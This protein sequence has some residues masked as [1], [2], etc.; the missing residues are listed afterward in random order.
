MSVEERV[1]RSDR[2]SLEVLDFVRIQGELLDLTLSDSGRQ[3]ISNEP[4]HIDADAL[5]TLQRQTAYI[6][7]LFDFNLIRPRYTFPALDSV[8]ASLRVPGRSLDAPSLLEVANYL[9]AA[10][11]LKR[12][13]SLRP[14]ERFESPIVGELG[15][16][17]DLPELGR[18]IRDV[19]SDDGEVREDIASIVAILRRLKETRANL[20]ILARRYLQDRRDFWQ[21]DVP[22]IKDDRTVLPL[23]SDHRGSVRGIVRDVSNTGATIFIEP[24]EIVD[25]NNEISLIGHEY[26]AEIARILRETTT[27]VRAHLPR[28][29]ALESAVAKLDSL[30]ARARFGELHAGRSAEISEGGVRLTSARHPLLG[31]LALP[32]D[33]A[34]GRACSVII[35]GPNAGGKTV[36]LKTIGLFAL[37]HQFGIPLPVSDGA[38][39][40]LFD[41][42]FA[43]V[44]DEQSIDESLSTFSGHARNLSRFLA[45]ATS[46][47]LVLLDELGSGTDPVEGAAIAMAVVDSLLDRGTTVVVT[48]HHGVLK[49][50]GYT[51]ENAV[52]ASVSFDSK[53]HAP[54]Y[55]VVMGTPGESHALDVAESSGIPTEVVAKARAYLDDESSDVAAMISSLTVKQLQLEERNREFEARRAALSEKQREVDLTSL[56]LKQRELE[57]RT[58]GYSQLTKQ[59]DEHRSRLERLVQEVKLGAGTNE[60]KAVKEYVDDL[61]TAVNEEREAIEQARYE[62]RPVTSEIMPGMQVVVGESHQR[63]TVVRR[64]KKGSWVVATD[65]VRITLPEHAIRGIVSDPVE[66]SVQADVPN[67]TPP[68]TLDLRGMRLVEAIEAVSVQIDRSIASGLQAFDVIHGLGEGVLKDGVREF[69]SDEPSVSEFSFAPPDQGGYGKTVVRLV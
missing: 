51:R 46:S 44:G 25:R 27:E 3:R 59:M 1:F 49:N 41:A 14:D 64:A 66:I 43:D 69:L 55:R 42:V 32:I 15:A 39:M 62:L 63:A 6:I 29:E 13:M 48:T 53:R 54:T 36:T 57:L 45:L 24:D 61:Q 34:I 8:K 9:R 4:F 58:H 16:L 33:V 28:I 7:R 50:Y 17:D 47:S 65:R 20:Q 19:I 40:P 35:T 23:K 11:D 10:R 60:T 21:S 67:V 37:M 30:Y 18:T 56:R 52:N 22:T 2:H 26:A 5:A 68:A 31:K 38:E 12:W